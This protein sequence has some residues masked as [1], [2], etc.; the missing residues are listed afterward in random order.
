[1]VVSRC[2]LKTFSCTNSD[3]GCGTCKK[4]KCVSDLWHFIVCSNSM[5]RH[6]H[7]TPKIGVSFEVATWRSL[8]PGASS[9][10]N[11]VIRQPNTVANLSKGFSWEEAQK[12]RPCFVTLIASQITTPITPPFCFRST[13]YS[14]TQKILSAIAL[15]VVY[16]KRIQ[17]H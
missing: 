16:S 2:V 11:T 3:S 10:L 8:H 4:K 17:H 6:T 14:F 9:V 1:M 5:L 7:I 15:K 13:Q 12:E